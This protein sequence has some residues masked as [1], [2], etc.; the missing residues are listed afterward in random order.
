MKHRRN[1]SWSLLVRSI[2]LSFPSLPWRAH[3]AGTHLLPNCHSHQI[4]IA[5]GPSDQIQHGAFL[6]GFLY[7]FSSLSASATFIEW[8]T[9]S[10]VIPVV[11]VSVPWLSDNRSCVTVMLAGYIMTSC[12]QGTPQYVSEYRCWQNYS[13]GSC[14]Y[15][16]STYWHKWLST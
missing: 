2:L 4:K 9:A 1:K 7:Q 3:K 5:Y 10:C 11:R 16:L 12:V 8:L 14:R 6:P 15:W 13:E